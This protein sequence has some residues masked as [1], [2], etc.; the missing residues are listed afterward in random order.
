MVFRQPNCLY[1]LQ[2]H[3]SRC[4]KDTSACVSYSSQ[5]QHAQGT[6]DI[7]PLKLAFVPLSHIIVTALVYS[8]A[9]LWLFT[10][11]KYCCFYLWHA[12]FHL[13]VFTVCYFTFY[14]SLCLPVSTSQNIYRT[15][16]GYSVIWLHFNVSTWP[17]NKFQTPWFA[18]QDLYDWTEKDFSQFIL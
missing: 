14:L 16:K 4:M 15:K 9:Q 1:K 10:T 13:S 12:F 11:V 18:F 2:I 5:T 7:F 6:I 8:F 3:T 17:E